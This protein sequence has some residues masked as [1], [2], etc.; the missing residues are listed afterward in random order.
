[1]RSSL[2][3]PRDIR[4][5]LDAN[6]SPRAAA[7]IDNVIHVSEVDALS[8]THGGHS[9]ADDYDIAVWCA[10]NSYVLVTCDNDFRSR[11]QRTQFI[12]QV[13]VEVIIF[14]YELA[15]LANH[16]STW[17]DGYLYGSRSSTGSAT[18]RASGCKFGAAHCVRTGRTR[19]R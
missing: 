13:G 9:N 17:R 11:R 19:H 2:D 14:T 4:F 5:C 10:E 8:R 1:M 18:P 3:T 12:Q 7:G 15:G 16:V 6:I